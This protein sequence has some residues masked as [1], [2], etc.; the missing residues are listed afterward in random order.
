M[1][2]II[3]CAGIGFIVTFVISRTMLQGE[4]KLVVRI[5]P[6]LQDVQGEKAGTPTIGG[7]AFCVGTTVANLATGINPV[8]LLSMW[9]FCLIGLWDDVEKTHT[10]NGDGLSPRTKLLSQLFVSVL[11]VS[12][13]A[14]S[15]NLHTTMFGHNWGVWYGLFAIL[16]LMFFVNAVNITDGLDGL[17][18]LV[19]ILP[20]ILL[21]V[22]G[23]NP[24]LYAF[25]GSLAAFLVF[26]LKP[27]KYFMGDA[28]SHAIGAVLA[29]TALMD[30][31]EVV[32][33][34]ASSAL[35]IELFSSLVQIIFIRTLGKKVFS[36]AP[37]HHAF[38]K[39]GIAE[40]TIVT[41]YTLLTVLVSLVAYLV[42]R[43]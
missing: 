8:L 18:G 4:R 40:R 31:T 13:L 25:I 1:H 23:A 10:L 5:K 32:T 27:A 15:G 20:L 3:A 28:G 11:V 2:M 38:E 30:K 21:C 26:N 17:A 33:L 9:L 19:S 12:T 14:V 7:I 39:K 35:V 41:G 34:I 24:F 37:L 16:Y 22:I 43:G 36:I 6:E 29:T 42:Y